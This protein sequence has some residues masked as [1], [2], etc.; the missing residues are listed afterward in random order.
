M[1]ESNLKKGTGRIPECLFNAPRASTI[2]RCIL[3][4]IEEAVID[5]GVIVREML[6]LKLE[7]EPDDGKRENSAVGGGSK[8]LA[9][10]EYS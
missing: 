5:A 2:L 3:L 6:M 4:T 8:Y 10:R 9:E 1:C 7:V